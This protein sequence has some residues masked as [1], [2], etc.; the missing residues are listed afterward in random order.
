[1]QKSSLI[2]KKINFKVYGVTTWETIAIYKL[3]NIL[4]SKGSQTMK[5][6][7]LIECNTS[8]ISLESYTKYGGET[9]SRPF[10]K[11]SILSISQD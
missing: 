6:G 1:M 4:R 9:I 2:R 10:Y 11:K 5:F 8:N 7:V 3:P